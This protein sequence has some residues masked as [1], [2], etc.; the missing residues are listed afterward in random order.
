M[1]HS[2]DVLT[3]W[4]RAVWSNDQ[5]KVIP[6]VYSTGRGPVFIQYLLL[7]L[8]GTGY[9][10]SPTV[11]SLSAGKAASRGAWKRCLVL[12]FI[13]S[14]DRNHLRCGYVC[15]G[16]LGVVFLLVFCSPTTRSG[17]SRT[18]PFP[19]ILRFLSGAPGAPPAL[20]W[21]CTYTG[22]SYAAGSAGLG[23]QPLP[24]PSCFR[25]CSWSHSS[26]L[27]RCFFSRFFASLSSA[28]V[29]L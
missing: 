4:R 7:P 10:F 11:L 16:I 26:F 8:P 2:A 28:D 24:D 12:S 9:R 15:S 19:R 5:E 29:L 27:A 3:G 14:C 17:A 21:C 25:S 1:G 13:L 22:A 23:L 6:R 18:C 20:L